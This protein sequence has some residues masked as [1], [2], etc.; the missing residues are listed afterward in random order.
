MHGRAP[1]SR[2]FSPDRCHR[3]SRTSHIA[4][5]ATGHAFPPA[6]A[7]ARLV[8]HTLVLTCT[9]PRTPNTPISSAHRWL[10]ARPSL[11]RCMRP[12]LRASPGYCGCGHARYPALARST[13]AQPPFP[14]STVV[15][16]PYRAPQSTA[17]S[18]AVN[19]TRVSF[20]PMLTVMPPADA[21]SINLLAASS[22]PTK[23]GNRSSTSRFACSSA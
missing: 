17:A 8:E 11:D 10:P 20:P 5:L 13:V 12:H 19:R 6:A 1:K 18:A 21:A 2:F 15:S 7:P 22:A 4:A 3:S 16:Q 23:A 9:R 14:Q